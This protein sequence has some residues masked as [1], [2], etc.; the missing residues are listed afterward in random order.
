MAGTILLEKTIGGGEH[1]TLTMRRVSVE[2]GDDWGSQPAVSRP[3]VV[4]EE[5]TW[6][7]S[8]FRRRR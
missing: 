3:P 5:E 7:S 6:K 8:L 4:E 1:F 2:H